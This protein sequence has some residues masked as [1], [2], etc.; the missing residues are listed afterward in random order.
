M[1][2]REGA[3]EEEIRTSTRIRAAKRRSGRGI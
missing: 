3:K 1:G 2:E